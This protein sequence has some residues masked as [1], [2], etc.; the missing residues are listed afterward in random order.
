ML[1]AR[2]GIAKLKHTSGPPLIGLLPISICLGIW[3]LYETRRAFRPTDR[4]GLMLGILLM[5][6]S[7]V[8]LNA[9]WW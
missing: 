2:V 8:S 4:S 7:I 6:V 9:A 3:G 5:L 1:L